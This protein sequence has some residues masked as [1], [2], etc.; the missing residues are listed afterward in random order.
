[1]QYSEPQCNATVVCKWDPGDVNHPIEYPA[2]C[3]DTTPQFQIS[4]RYAHIGQ[5]C[6]SQASA[7]ACL[8]TT[9]C[10]WTGSACVRGKVFDY[11]DPD[12]DPSTRQ[13]IFAVW[14]SADPSFINA[15]G[16]PAAGS[17][18][19]TF[20]PPAAFT[21]HGVDL[22]YDHVKR[23]LEE[24]CLYAAVSADEAIQCR[25]GISLRWGRPEDWNLAGAGVLNEGNFRTAG[26]ATQSCNQDSD[27]PAGEYCS[28]TDKKC[29][30]YAALGA[31]FRNAKVELLGPQ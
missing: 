12:G 11:V 31:T 7:T 18:P 24:N 9:F 16:E 19:F 22:T 29:M 27:C 1:L 8:Q 13:P 15:Y 28:P 4:S 30:G 14:V 5:A 17:A 6:A 23:M 10:A 25:D 2:V 21:H 20:D 26:D 3:R